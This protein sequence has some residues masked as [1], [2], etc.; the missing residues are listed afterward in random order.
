MEFLKLASQ[1][2]KNAKTIAVVG[3]SDKPDRSSYGVA[4]YLCQFYEVIPV[5]PNLKMW[6]GRRAYGSLLDIPFKIDVVNI[7]R[8]SEEVLPIVKDA[9]QI[10]AKGIWMQLGVIN[11]DA[12]KLAQEAGVP[13]IMDACIAVL[14]RQIN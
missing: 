6:N 1:I 5:N 4:E 2:L 8:R 7:F 9:I 11:Q 10:G 14:H 12:E 13:L 3:L